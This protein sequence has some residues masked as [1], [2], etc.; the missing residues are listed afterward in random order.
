MDLWRIE[1]G[2]WNLCR[3][4]WSVCVPSRSVPHGHGTI[5]LSPT[6]TRTK[7]RSTSLGHPLPYPTAITV[8]TAVTSSSGYL[9]IRIFP[10]MSL[11]CSWTGGESQ[12]QRNPR[13]QDTYSSRVSGYPASWTR[14]LGE[15]SLVLEMWHDAYVPRATYSMST[16]HG[17]G[18]CP[19]WDAARCATR[20]YFHTCACGYIQHNLHWHTDTPASRAWASRGT[21]KPNPPTDQ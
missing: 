19:S 2:C 14:H 17:A 12:G 1:C 16:P 4:I 13:A 11:V 20:P 5:P 15:A 6:I 3:S 9:D 18:S 7:R 21:S 10:H 8:P